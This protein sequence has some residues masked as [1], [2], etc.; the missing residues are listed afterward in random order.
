MSQNAEKRL[1]T[2]S[3][4]QSG[5]CVIVRVCMCK[6]FGF[7]SGVFVTDQQHPGSVTANVKAPH[8]VLLDS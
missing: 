7:E 2:H 1:E 8:K 3:D 4:A 5:V 6:A